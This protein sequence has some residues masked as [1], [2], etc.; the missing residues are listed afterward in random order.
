MRLERDVLA[1]H[2]DL[3]IISYGLND[4]GRREEGLEGYLQNIRDMVRRCREAGAEV[5][6]MSANGM[7]TYPDARMKQQRQIDIANRCAATQKEGWCRRYVEEA[8]RVA[9]EEGGYFADCNGRWEALAAAGANM[10]AH[11]SNHINHPTKEM[12]WLFANTLFETVF[13]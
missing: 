4:C 11:L 12:H 7:C 8:G 1:Y 5:I 10:T 3:V 6:F 2:P 13:F 9:V